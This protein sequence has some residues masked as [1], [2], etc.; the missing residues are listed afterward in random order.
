[1]KTVTVTIPEV[2]P[3]LEVHMILVLT[4]DTAARFADEI[5]AGR[6][7]PHPL[8]R[9]VIEALSQMS[10]EDRRAYAMHGVRVLMHRA[11]SNLAG[12]RDNVPSSDHT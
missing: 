1:M 12:G 10:E 7:D 2:A 6:P 8:A 5:D 11:R 4:P 3:Q 9:S